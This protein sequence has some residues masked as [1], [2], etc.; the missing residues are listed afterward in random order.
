MNSKVKL[1][2]RNKHK[3]EYD[4]NRLCKAVPQLAA[5]IETKYGKRTLDFADPQA[6]KL[7]NKALL[8]DNYDIDFWDL[9]DGFLCP[10]IPGRADYIHYLADLL[11]STFA[12]K[13]EHKF[14][15]VLDIGTGASCIYP[16]LGYKSYA[17][18][19]VATD[20]EIPSIKAAKKIVSAN[21]GL[22][23]VIELR[24]QKQANQIFQGVFKEHEKFHLTLCNPPFHDSPEQAAQ[25]S[26]KK[27]QNLGRGNQKQKSATPLLNFAGRS[28]ELWCKG[29]ELAF[30][31]KMIRESRD[32]GQ[33]VIWFT[34]LVSKKESLS[35]IKLAL[36]KANVTQTKTVKMEQGNKVSRFIAWSFLT[37]EQQ[38]S[39]FSKE[40]KL[41]C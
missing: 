37:P 20:I 25:G 41:K 8:K 15:K 4:F 29:G 32:Y 26:E 31:R 38:I 40:G 30:I 5:F 34:S 24:H 36:K 39:Y 19:F 10:P 33:Q 11:K 27:W 6:V 14:V 28:N 12:D 22:S 23:K 9:P 16:L 21:K 7:L 35:K 1:H 13:L 3:Q 17:W 2:P 18:Q